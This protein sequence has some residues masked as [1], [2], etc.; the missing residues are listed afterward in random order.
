MPISFLTPKAAALGGAALLLGGLLVPKGIAMK[1]SRVEPR[2]LRTAGISSTSKSSSSRSKATQR[3][4]V[5]SAS[6][7][8]TK[9]QRK[10]LPQITVSKSGASAAYA[11]ERKAAKSNWQFLNRSVRAKIDAAKVQPQRWKMVVVHSSGT[12]SGGATAF[13]YYHRQVK[14]MAHGLA[15]HFVIGNGHGTGDGQIEVGQRW[16]LQE[17]GGHLRSGTQNEIALG[18]CL[19]GNFEKGRPT[20]KQVEALDEL[21]DYLQA[22]VGKVRVTTHRLINIRPTLCP[23]RNFPSKMFVEP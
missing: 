8:V 5:Q 16:S 9:V 19:V 13:D 3:P 20:E 23:G 7:P 21:I 18:I 4:T 15:Y 11:Y 14:H 2:E 12:K 6:Q 10:G 17:A 1:D 22:K